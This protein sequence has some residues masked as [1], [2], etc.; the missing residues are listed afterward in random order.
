LYIF[1]DESGLFIPSEDNKKW[2]SVGALVVPEQSIDG[3]KEALSKLKATNGLTDEEEFKR[4]RPDCSSESYA[5]FLNSLRI[6]HCTLHVLSLNGSP[7]ASSGL[8]KLKE[9]MKHAIRNYSNKVTSKKALVEQTVELIDKLSEQQFAQCML[10][11]HMLKHL[12]DKVPA[13]YAKILPDSLEDFKWRVDQKN[14]KET[15]YDKVFK[16]LY[17]GIA[18]VASLS[19]PGPILLGSEYD[20]SYFVTAYKPDFDG[21]IQGSIE[22]STRLFEKDMNHLA[23]YLVGIDIIKILTDDFKLDDSKDSF[24]LQSVDLLV[25][26][27]NRCLKRN[28][29]D[30][31]KMAE[32]LG[33]LMVNSPLD[34]MRALSLM[35]LSNGGMIKNDTAKV[36]DIM[37]KNSIQLFSKDFRKNYS[38]IV[39][40]YNNANSH[41]Q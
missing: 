27:V 18:L 36:I 35:S 21:S 22:E 37:D 29:T 34:N 4:N 8:Q 5:E 30:N 19:Q 10:Q 9:N 14:L 7:S 25:S 13:L 26:S 11:S 12:L 23:K 16:Y 2:S 38:H 28:F 39:N 6:L 1:I 24:G 33:K 15:N 3:L 32:H 31:E 20:Y 41:G 17:S 40:K